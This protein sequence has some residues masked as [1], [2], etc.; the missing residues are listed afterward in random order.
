MDFKSVLSMN[1]S[2]KAS[3]ELLE[4]SRS[5]S[6]KNDMRIVAEQKHNPFIKNGNVD[7]DA[8]I[9]FV[10]RYNEF[11]NHQPKPFRRMIDNDM[12]L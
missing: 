2:E 6:L 8:Y 4:L 11:I 1:I 12:K 9:E 5:G 10:S 3:K 7:V